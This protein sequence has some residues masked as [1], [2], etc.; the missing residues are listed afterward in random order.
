MASNLS[1]TVRQSDIVRDAHSGARDDTDRM[2]L[3]WNFLRSVHYH[4]EPLFNSNEL[5]DPV[6]YLNLY[7]TGFCDDAGNSFCS[8]NY[9]ANFTAQNYGYDP[10]NRLL[11]GHVQGELFFQ[12]KWHFMDVD[13]NMFYLDAENEHVLSG[14]R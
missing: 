1:D 11:H 13:E 12:N 2:F 8:L 4:S 10:K 3:S 5:H 6:K 7:G 9:H 14:D